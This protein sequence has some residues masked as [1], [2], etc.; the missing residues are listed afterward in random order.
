MIDVERVAELLVD[1]IVQLL[2]HIVFTMLEFEETD[3]ILEVPLH[4]WVIKRLVDVEELGLKSVSILLQ[5][6]Q[7][8]LC[9]S[10]VTT[11]VLDDAASLRVLL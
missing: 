9:A 2:N 11:A 6:R 4:L 10:T 5:I 1:T 7:L 3:E 8:V